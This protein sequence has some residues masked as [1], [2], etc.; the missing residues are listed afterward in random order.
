MWLGR[1]PRSWL[2]G[3]YSDCAE[4]RL[5]ADRSGACVGSAETP[6]SRPVLRCRCAQQFHATVPKCAGG[7]DG[8]TRSRDQTCRDHGAWRGGRDAGGRRRG[9]S[10][11]TRRM[12]ERRAWEEQRWAKQQLARLAG[13]VGKKRARGEDGFSR[14]DAAPTAK[15][16]LL[17]TGRNDLRGSS[18]R[19]M[20]CFLGVECRAAACR[21]AN[22]RMTSV[23]RRRAPALHQSV[24]DCSLVDLIST[25]WIRLNSRDDSNSCRGAA[26]RRADYSFVKVPP[27]SSRFSSW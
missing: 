16:V 6:L 25:A 23:A 11:A 3:V 18:T 22:F 1:M 12:G 15:R 26:R 8:E 5:A 27:A 21:R 14:N 17:R 7:N 24:V 20:S 9:A 10:P 2:R 4:Y 19:C 13:G